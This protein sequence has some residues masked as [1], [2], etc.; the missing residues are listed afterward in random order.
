MVQKQKHLE[1]NDFQSDLLCNTA[2]ICKQIPLLVNRFKYNIG[3]LP[4]AS[5]CAV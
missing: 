5:I 3:L 4:V 1:N 2:I